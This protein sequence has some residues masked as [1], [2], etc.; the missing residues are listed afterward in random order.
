MR[1]IRHVFVLGLVCAITEGAASRSWADPPD[2]LTDKAA[3]LYDEG[4][5]AYKKSKWPEARASFLAAWSLKKHWQIAASL[6]DCEVQL[7]LN[8]DAAEHLAYFFRAAPRDRQSPEVRRLYDT[9]R[10]K[11]GT[12]S[13]IVDLPGADVAVDGKVLGRSPLED[14][15]FVEPGPHVVE[16]RLRTHLASARAEAGP[17][18]SRTV[19]LS[20][21]DPPPVKPSLAVIV[22]GAV[23]GAAGAATGLAFLAV[24]TG[25]VSSANTTLAG[26]TVSQTR[27][28]S[29]PQAGACSEVLSQ[30]R[31]ADTFHNVGVPLAAVGGVVAL[32]T[33]G[34][35]LWPRAPRVEQG[36]RIDV[37]PIVG[38]QVGGVWINGSF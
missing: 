21:K 31:A 7:G 17:G 3:T 13:V 1:A 23:V 32:G 24:S 2:A 9:A 35:A 5:A 18:A 15:V 28:S 4:A 29:P 37:L 11:V 26:I 34:Y 10:A 33:L 30:R 36:A 22:T 6:G 38:P 16:A 27:C 25:K 8:R 20:V 14:P 12:L 19:E